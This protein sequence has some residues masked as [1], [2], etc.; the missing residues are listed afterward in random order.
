MTADPYPRLRDDLV[1]P[2]EVL[3]WAYQSFDR[4]ALATSLGPQSI[5]VLHLLERL[6][7]R[8]DVLLLDTGLLFEETLQLAD[9]VSERFSIPIQRVLPEQT[10]QQQAQTH[11]AAL[12]ERDPDLCCRLRKVLPLREALTGY[13]AWIA[14]LR[15]DQSPT[16]QGVRT[17]GW[18]EQNQRVKLAPLAHWTRE[19]VLDWIDTHELPYNPL[20]E[21]GYASVGCWP[22]TRATRSLVSHRGLVQLDERAGRWPDHP[23]KTECGLHAPKE[24]P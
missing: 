18:D 2:S 6:A 23:D 9:R 5:V 16:R 19:Q 10:V 12:W 17:V 13:D 8:V 7:L 11:G 14:G 4:I 15:R 22:C 20:L 1:D 21:R 3:L 24:T